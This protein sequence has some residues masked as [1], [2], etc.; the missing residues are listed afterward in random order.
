MSS[1]PDPE[2]LATVGYAGSYSH[3][4]ADGIEIK[5]GDIAEAAAREAGLEFKV[6]GWTGGQISF[7]DMPDFY[8]SVDA[9]LISSVSEGAQM[10][11]K[12]GAAAGRLVISTPVGD[13]P[14]RASQALGIVAPIES[15]KYRKF[16]A[17]TLRYYKDNP[18]LFTERCRNIQDAARQLD[19][20]NVIG[21]WIELIE[22]VKTFPLQHQQ[23]GRSTK[24]VAPS[25]RTSVFE[26]LDIRNELRGGNKAKV[27][28][29]HELSIRFHGRSDWSP[30]ATLLENAF[31]KA[32]ALETRLPPE[33]LSMT[34]MSGRK[35]RI[36]VNNLIGSIPK[37][38]LSRNRMLVRIHRVRCDVR[39]PRKNNLY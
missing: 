20:P 11:V 27:Q 10:P 39:Q 37:S 36:L 23:D 2:R 5:R 38:A 15:H 3:K 19:W 25:E 34:G 18:A 21:D 6:A 1:S 30:L 32:L 4:T 28:M 7:H 31:K 24:A 22:T 16:V 13:F 14:L 33:V 8:K 29:A 9:V 12:E 26:H 17:D 35:Y